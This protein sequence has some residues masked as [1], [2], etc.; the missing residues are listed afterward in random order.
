MN[1]QEKN[2]SGSPPGNY[3]QPPIV[4]RTALAKWDWRFFAADFRLIMVFLSNKPI[5]AR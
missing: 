5:M 3:F 4:I 1:K 2:I